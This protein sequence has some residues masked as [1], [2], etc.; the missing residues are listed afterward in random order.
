[1]LPKTMVT[2]SPM[3][4]RKENIA[5]CLI[6]EDHL[7]SMLSKTSN[8][9]Y[10]PWGNK[11]APKYPHTCFGNFSK[12]F[13]VGV[14]KPILPKKTPDYEESNAATT[15]SIFFFTVFKHFAFF[16]KNLNFNKTF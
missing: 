8:T 7:K 6:I 10:K 1:M 3:T 16:S 11:F 15:F 4:T 2:A 9:N 12:E 14:K 5:S 13:V